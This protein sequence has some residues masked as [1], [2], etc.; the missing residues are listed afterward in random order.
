MFKDL[1]QRGSDKLSELKTDALKF[2]S[3]KFLHAAMSGS[4]LVSFA[5][6]SIDQVEKDKMRVFI[7]NNPAL[8]IYSRVDVLE[9]FNE[10]LSALEMDLDMGEAKAMDALAKIKGK[11]DEARLVLRMVVSIGKSDGDF[12]QSEKAMVIKIGRELGLD[13]NDFID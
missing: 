4:A 9:A 13:A 3:K 11:D 8:S 10:Y 6:G 7:E 5:D 2:K 12:D 1:L